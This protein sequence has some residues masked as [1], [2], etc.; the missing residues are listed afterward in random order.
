MALRLRP[1]F[2]AIAESGV[3]VTQG[4]ARASRAGD[5]ALAITNLEAFSAYKTNEW[6]RNLIHF[7]LLSAA[8]PDNKEWVFP[9]YPEFL[10]QEGENRRNG[11]SSNHS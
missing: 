2:S 11:V 1:G 10:L 3:Q 7:A 5:R 8:C 6:I 4:T 9:F